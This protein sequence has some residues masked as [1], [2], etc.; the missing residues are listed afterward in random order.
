MKKKERIT[1]T[2]KIEESLYKELKKLAIEEESTIIELIE[3][4][5]KELLEKYEKK[6]A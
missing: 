3:K 1:I 6:I 2:T 5:I 4:A